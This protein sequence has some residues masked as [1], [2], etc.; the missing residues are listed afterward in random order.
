MLRDEHVARMQH[1]VVHLSGSR[2]VERRGQLR[3]HPQRVGGKEGTLVAEHDV[4][5]VG[6]HVFLREIGHHAVG[7]GRDRRGHDGM[8]Q[9]SRDETL[10]LGDQLV[11]PFRRQIEPQHLD[12][13]QPGPIGIE[14]TKDRTE[15]P[16]TDLMQDPERAERVRRRGA[17]SFRMQWD[18][19]SG[20]RTD[21]STAIRYCE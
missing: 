1:A 11:Q 12:G 7:A 19:S 10:E 15:R 4:E 8:G 13:D 16:R 2:E 3:R 9:L 5:R 18:I 21:G 20:R 6:G 17:G 14:R